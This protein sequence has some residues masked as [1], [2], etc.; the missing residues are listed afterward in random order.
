MRAWPWRGSRDCLPGVGWTAL[1]Q[2]SGRLTLTPSLSLSPLFVSVFRPTPSP[3]PDAGLVRQRHRDPVPGVH[4]VHDPPRLHRAVHVRRQVRV[5]GGREKRKNA[6]RRATVDGGPLSSR[7]RETAGFL[8]A[9]VRPAGAPPPADTLPI[10]CSRTQAGLDSGVRAGTVSGGAQ[11][12]RRER[13]SPAWLSLPPP[14]VPRPSIH[15]QPPS[16]RQERSSRRLS[17]K[18]HTHT[19]TTQHVRL[20]HGGH[21]EARPV[22]RPEEEGDGEGQGG[23]SGPTLKHEKRKK[24]GRK[25]TE[26]GR[27]LFLSFSFATV[28]ALGLAWI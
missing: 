8:S 17:L 22:R 14:S 10:A 9:C 20:Q 3:R 24:K 19:H 11:K 16:T 18:K 1:S 13:H 12:A 25:K 23:D 6:Q 7:E 4:R 5:E 27:F 2:S 15:P 26:N 21:Q 28:V